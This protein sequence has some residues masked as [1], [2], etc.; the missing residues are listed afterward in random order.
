MNSIFFVLTLN[1]TS[2]PRIQDTVTR[3]RLKKPL[4]SSGIAYY[5]GSLTWT[6]GWSNIL[7]W[8]HQKPTRTNSSL[9][10][11]PRKK[12]FTGNLYSWK[13]LRNLLSISGIFLQSEDRDCWESTR[14]NTT[15][16]NSPNSKQTLTLGHCTRCHWSTSHPFSLAK[17]GQLFNKL[18]ALTPS[19]DARNWKPDQNLL[20]F[21]WNHLISFNRKCIL[22]LSE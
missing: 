2:I 8:P 5:L 19:Y 21:L 14:C 15:T 6:V 7:P 1:L 4:N 17:C 16:H 3:L 12:H 10:V 11:E 9:Q 13:S 22:P 18:S 20:D